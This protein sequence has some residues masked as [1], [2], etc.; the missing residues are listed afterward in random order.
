M[1]AALVVV[2]IIFLAVRYG[3]EIL[4]AATSLPC[5]GGGASWILG[6]LDA[7]KTPAPLSDLVFGVLLIQLFVM[8]LGIV[9]H[10]PRLASAVYRFMRG[11]ARPGD[12]LR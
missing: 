11:H 6:T 9:L 4:L 5:V 12:A 10:G 2:Q 7:F 1:I 8:V 3:H